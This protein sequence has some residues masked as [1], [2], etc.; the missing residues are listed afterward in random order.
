MMITDNCLTP[1]N[2]DN[3]SRCVFPQLITDPG[4]KTSSRRKM[5]ATSQH[6]QPPHVDR[7]HTKHTRRH[8]SAS[9]G[10]LICVP[11]KHD[12]SKTDCMNNEGAPACDSSVGVSLASPG[13]G[14]SAFIDSQP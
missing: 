5:A 10:W 9:T 13:P 8:A 3:N 4:S 2:R 7:E 6:D 11:V 12:F 14:L 1:D